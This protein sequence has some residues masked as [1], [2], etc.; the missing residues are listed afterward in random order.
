M[1]KTGMK[2]GCP[3]FEQGHTLLWTLLRDSRSFHL[4]NEQRGD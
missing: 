3:F 1:N 4:S 2:S